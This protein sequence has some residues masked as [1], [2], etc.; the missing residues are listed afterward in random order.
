M[1]VLITTYCWLVLSFTCDL[2]RRS[3]TK[4]RKKFPISRS[5]AKRH[6]QTVTDGNAFRTIQDL[7]NVLMRNFLNYFVGKISG[8][9]YK[10][11]LFFSLIKSR[12]TECIIRVS[13][14]DVAC[15]STVVPTTV[16]QYLL[17]GRFA[18]SPM[19][20]HITRCFRCVS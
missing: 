19:Y 2:P 17:P 3:F 10:K 14:F 1:T 11:N 20:V 15:S 4:S 8:Q 7:Y 5:G 13:A 16:G 18:C 12:R 9:Y 6:R